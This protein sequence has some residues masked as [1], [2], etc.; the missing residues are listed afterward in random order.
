M[1]K[2]GKILIP[3]I[4]EAVAPVTSEEQQLYDHIDF[5]LD[6]FAR[7]VGAETLLHGCKVLAGACPSVRLV[8]CPV[9]RGPSGDSWAIRYTVSGGSDFQRAGREGSGSVK[10]PSP[11]LTP[12]DPASPAGGCR[13]PGPR[14]CLTHT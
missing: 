7:D 8:A 2:K 11:R 3:G 10:H 9:S 6:E 14:G 12:G 1:D 13:P 4:N 5:D